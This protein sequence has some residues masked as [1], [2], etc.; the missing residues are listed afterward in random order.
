M[1]L[2]FALPSPEHGGRE[3]MSVPR[4][5]FLVPDR[6]PCWLTP[7]AIIGRLASADLQLTDPRVSEAHALLSLRGGQFVL[8]ALRRGLRVDGDDKASIRLMPGMSIE[9]APG[10]AIGVADVELPREVLCLRGLPQGPL[11]LSASVYS[12]LTEGLTEG[13]GGSVV[14]EPAFVGHAAAHLW[15]AGERWFW[16][17]AGAPPQEIEAGERRDV[18]GHRLEISSSPV[19]ELFVNETQRADEGRVRL[20]LY[21]NYVVLERDGKRVRVGGRLADLIRLMHQYDR[22]VTWEEVAR[23]LWSSRE[24]RLLRQ[25]WDRA[26]Y[27]LR[28]ML[29]EAGLPP[30]I[31]HGD[32]YGNFL[33]ELR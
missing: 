32:G 13:A 20:V 33:L 6:Q 11:V 24:H 21:K 18:G 26:T 22:A 2:A 10:L 5:E 14:V 17:D 31:L 19:G 28:K 9:F 7:G 27:R 16:Q 25:N 4:V 8:L 1:D 30:Q 29:R 15:S 23:R 3:P 12:I